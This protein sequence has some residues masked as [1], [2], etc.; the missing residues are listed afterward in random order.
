MRADERCSSLARIGERAVEAVVKT[1][2]AA[3]AEREHVSRDPRIGVVVR[4]LETGD[5]EQPVA[6]G[7]PLGLG[8][9]GAEVGLEAR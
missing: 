7:C 6:C 8:L 5:H 1:D 4:E 9:D 3:Q 2:E